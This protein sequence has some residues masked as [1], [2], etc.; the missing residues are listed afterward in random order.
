MLFFFS[1]KLC[2]AA[3]TRDN[4]ECHKHSACTRGWHADAEILVV[5]FWS[6][7]HENFVF[8][9]VTAFAQCDSKSL[10]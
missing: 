8:H 7:N 6:I 2:A 5:E 1:G 10:L 9:C 4:S 3:A